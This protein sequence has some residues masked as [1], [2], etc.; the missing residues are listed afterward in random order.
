MQDININL[1]AKLQSSSH[2]TAFNLENQILNLNIADLCLLKKVKECNSKAHD[3]NLLASVCVC[4]CFSH[5]LANTP[6]T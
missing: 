1:Y 5:L 3:R 6:L 4:V 2:K